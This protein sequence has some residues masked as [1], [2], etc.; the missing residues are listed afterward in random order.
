MSQR[1]PPP[2]EPIDQTLDA[3]RAGDAPP[4]VPLKLV[5]V[6][7]PDEGLEVPLGA[8]AEIGAEPP[9]AL[10]LTDKSVSR[11]HAAV[12]AARGRIVVRDLESR[13]GTFL[14]GARLKEAEVP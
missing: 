9:C 14:G 6:G 8:L 4:L 5:V 3:S 10:V 7:G 12:E 13:N 1:P 2:N 11:R